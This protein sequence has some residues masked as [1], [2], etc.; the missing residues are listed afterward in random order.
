MAV[1]R[2]RSDVIGD[3]R[4]CHIKEDSARF[5][6]H[7]S[8]RFTPEQ[9]TQITECATE[10]ALRDLPVEVYPHPDE[11]E[12]LYWSCDGVVIP[13]GGTHLASTGAVGPVEV[14]R[15]NLGKGLERLT[16]VFPNRRLDLRPYHD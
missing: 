10:L 1:N 5:D 7:T 14:R 4:G 15:R 12:A 2:I 8:E 13:C 11:P 3:I 9:L 16:V 6:F